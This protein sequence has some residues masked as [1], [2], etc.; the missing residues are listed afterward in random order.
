MCRGLRALHRF[1]WPRIVS[2][3]GYTPTLPATVMKVVL[4]ILIATDSSHC[5]MDQ[6]TNVRHGPVFSPMLAHP[7]PT[8][9]SG[10]R[11]NRRHTLEG[12]SNTVATLHAVF[13]FHGP[14]GPE[15]RQ[16]STPLPDWTGPALARPCKLH[17][18]ETLIYKWIAHPRSD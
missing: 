18:R 10:T 14:P 8:S 7:F 9:L 4:T 6:G 1:T 15:C 17:T 12:P 5:L 16:G 2:S 11:F 3:R 13:F